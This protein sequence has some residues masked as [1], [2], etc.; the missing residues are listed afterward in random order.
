MKMIKAMTVVLML[1]LA[2]PAL[3]QRESFR[4]PDGRKISYEKLFEAVSEPGETLD[5][6]AVRLTPRLREFSDATHFEACGRFAKAPDGRFG[7][8][9]GTNHAHIACVVRNTL[10]PEGMVAINNSIH[11]HGTERGATMNKSDKTLMGDHLIGGRGVISVAGQRLDAFSEHDFRG[12]PGYLAAPN[13]TLHHRGSS[14]TVRI[15]SGSVRSEAE[16]AST[17]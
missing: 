9:V 1:G 14:S 15:V 16:V 2:M 10:V 6:F 12:G 11:S 5:E 13:A 8:I 4:L 17:E 3:A 7:V